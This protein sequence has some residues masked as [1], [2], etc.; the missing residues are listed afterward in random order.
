MPP[1]LPLRFEVGSPVGTGGSS[2]VYRATLLD[3]TP[4]ALK[5][6]HGDGEAARLA[7]EAELLALC[8]SPSLPRVL[9]A[10]RTRPGIAGVPPGRPYL[11]LS[12][13]EGRALAPRVLSPAERPALLLAVARDVGDALASLHELGFSHGDVKPDNVVVSGEG[14]PRAYLVDLGLAGAADQAIARGG[15]LRYLAPEHASGASDARARD[16]FAFGLLLAELEREEVATSDRPTDVAR[17]G[18]GSPFT[19]VIRALLST[20][21]SA[22]PS[23]SWVASRARDLLAAEESVEARR[24]HGEDRVARAYLRTRREELLR[25]AC[26]R[27]ELDVEGTARAWLEPILGVL[28]R[29]SELRGAP[30]AS[31]PAARVVSDLRGL[32]RARFLTALI[33]ASAATFGD[34]GPDSDA[35]LVDRLVSLSLGRD[36]RALV[37]TDLAAGADSLADAPLGEDPVSLAILLGAPAPSAAALDAGERLCF[38]GRAPEA[39]LLATARSLRLAGWIARANAVLSLS[40]SV[41]ALVERAE[42]ARRSGDAPSAIAIATEAS[43][44]GVSGQA[45]GRLLATLARIEVDRGAADAAARILATAPSTPAVAETRALVALRGGRLPEARR[46]AEDG[47]RGAHTDE[48]RARLAAVLGNVAHAEGNAEAALTS[49]LRAVDHATRA[50]AV[51]EEATYLTGVAASG[52][53]SG[54]LS[55]ALDA[56]TRATLLFEHLGRADDAARALLTRAAALAAAGATTLALDAARDALARARKAGD[57]R[58]RA[59]CHLLQADVLPET[60]PDGI[61]HARRAATLLGADLPEDRLRTSARLL[62]RG[63]DVPVAELDALADSPEIAA[64][65][66]LEWWSVRARLCA[67]E[68]SP[69][70]ADRVLAALAALSLVPCPENLRGEALAAGAT[71]AARIGDGDAARRFS[72]A[73][74]DAAT[75]LL[76][77]A[78]PELRT[79][80]AALPWIAERGAPRDTGILPEQ[81]GDVEAL[82]RALGTRDRLRPLLDQVL[83]ALVLW[84]GVERGLLLLRA[85]GDRLVPRAARNIARQDLHGVQLS[86][87]RSLAERALASGEPVVA[88]DATGELPEMVASVH[89]LKLR[90]V[91][92]VPLVARGEPLGVVYLDDRVRRGAF[93]PGELAWVRLVATLAAVAIAEARDQLALRRAARRA[94]RAEARV[95][96]LLSKKEAELG[97]AARELAKARGERATRYAYDGILGESEPVRTLLRLVDRVTDSDV[98]VLVVGES[99]S[100]KEL[101]ARAIHEN[102]RRGEGPFVSENCGAIPETLLETTLFGHVRGAFTGANR[103]HAGLFEVASGGTLFLDEIG[104]MSLGMQTKLLRVLEDGEVRPVGSERPRKVDVRVVA[105]THRDL[106]KMVDA[107]T[108]RRDLF[109]RL[110]VIALEVPPLRTRPGDVELLAKHFIQV[111]A[112]A[113]NIRLSRAALDVLA[114]YSWPGNVRQLENEIR[115]ALVLADGLIQPEH[116]SAEVRSGARAEHER[117]DGLNLRKRVDALEAALVRTALERTRGNQT[118]AAELLGLSRFGLQKMIRRLDIELPAS[119]IRDDG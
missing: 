11:V 85:P 74:V 51:V 20:A 9:D 81:L 110:N 27:V 13:V 108:F 4:V 103:P 53:D 113:R 99:G 35:D 47:L 79:N 109:Y 116:L 112:G 15:T 17:R 26:G 78:P 88:V 95:A 23:A 33:G 91:L 82:V 8:R 62:A 87:S 55:R 92:A 22:R 60:D 16:L 100:G 93:G 106:A 12:W 7:D 65:A 5:V 40:D 59:Y 115:R 111:H 39:L 84:T 1:E 97:V 102:G 73:S 63:A 2:T 89:A 43:A 68:R 10:G 61:E 29:A 49:F 37:P 44:R 98:P 105:A 54:E 64:P 58:C 90:S 96:S 45:K 114:T 42:C 38:S 57:A 83:D 24:A 107:G 34:V 28:S 6:G 70:R 19:T 118:R 30:R 76:R 71:L 86:L 48:E 41:D 31:T 32:E 67:R 104:E 77:G 46:L 21:P 75:R 52:F 25:A 80:V 119:A 69:V 56:S 117:E 66:R 36:V 3:G 101:V 72:T 50:G 18:D 94:R 14:P